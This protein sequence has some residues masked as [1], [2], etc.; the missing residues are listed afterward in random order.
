MFASCHPCK[1]GPAAT[2]QDEKYRSHKRVFT[3]GK[4]PRCTVCGRETKKLK[5][6]NDEVEASVTKANLDAPAAD[7]EKQKGRGRDKQQSRPG[8]RR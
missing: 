1:P 6:K 8:S 3:E 2:F 4:T 5:P 7:V